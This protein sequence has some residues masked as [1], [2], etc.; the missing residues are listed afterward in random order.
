MYKNYIFDLYGTL[1][2]IWT[3]E[4]SEVFWKKICDIYSLSGTDYSPEELRS[5]YLEFCRDEERILARQNIRY[6]EIDLA[7]VFARLYE[8]APARHATEK[9]IRIS[10]EWV[11]WTAN[12]FRMLSRKAF[13]VYENTR[14]T[15]LALKEK[16]CGVY[17]LSN[18]QHIFTVPEMEMAGIT[19]LFD[20][21]YISSDCRVRKPDPSFMEILLKEQNLD[22]RECVMIGNDFSSDIR[23]AMDCGMDSIF[24]NTDGYSKEERERRMKEVLRPD[25]RPRIIESGNIAELLEGGSSCQ[26]G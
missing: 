11:Y 16:G 20:A 26:N 14:S 3:D 18:A 6:P 5:A 24:L 23:I 12:M 10:D 13:F 21:V 25:Y 1:I 17:L 22:R 2:S 8:N 19:D 4:S 7:R 15:L 9:D